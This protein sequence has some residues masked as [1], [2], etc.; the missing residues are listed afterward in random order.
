M[1]EVVQLVVGQQESVFHGAAWQAGVKRQRHAVPE[2][3]F[4]VRAGRHFGRQ[5][6]MDAALAA[7]AHGVGLPCIGIGAVEG[8]I[9]HAQRMARFAGIEGNRLERQ[10]GGVFVLHALPVA[11][12]ETRWRHE[13]A[14]AAET[15]AQAMAARAQRQYGA[16]PQRHIGGRRAPVARLPL[17]ASGQL[18][19]TPQGREAYQAL[20][21]H[22]P[23][24][25]NVGW[26]SQ[27]MS[28][29]SAIES[30]NCPADSIILEVFETLY[31]VQAAESL[32]HLSWSDPDVL[33][34]SQAIPQSIGKISIRRKSNQAENEDDKRDPQP[35]SVNAHSSGW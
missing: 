23:A 27:L 7:G 20:Q 6:A 29:L 24:V 9:H 19:M 5:V 35:I 34:E 15:G 1:G 13:A 25:A 31:G 17:G 21:T 18:K 11:R 28:Q 4:R 8:V 22:L 16:R 12:I 26:N 14:L 10:D 2:H 32:K 3:D 30:G 33:Y